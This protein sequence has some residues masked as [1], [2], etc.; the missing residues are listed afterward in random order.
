MHKRILAICL[1][2]MFL[3]VAV[4]P[5]GFATNTDQVVITYGET[6][7]MSQQYKSVVDDYFA[8]KTNFDVNAVESK[9]ITA[10]DVNEISSGYSG[11]SYNSNQIFSSALLDLNQN[12]EIT[13]EV[14]NSITTITPQMYMSALKSAGIQGGHVYVTSPVSATGESALAGIMDCYEEATDVE[15]PDNVKAAANQEIST[16]AEIMNNSNVSADDLSKLVDDVKEKVNEENITDHAT[17][18]NII[19]D[20]STTYNINI[21]DSDIENL[22]NTIEQ[23]Q[24]VQDDANAYKEQISDIVDSSGDGASNTLSDNGFSLDGLFNTLFSIFNI[25]A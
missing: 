17:I 10:G 24:S 11:K 21:S 14:D 23:V 5:T 16:Q 20:Y 18:V 3:A 6:T 12:G 19:N 7:Y 2:T 1:V 25:N 9:V 15:I 22:A 8:S 13:V 4:I